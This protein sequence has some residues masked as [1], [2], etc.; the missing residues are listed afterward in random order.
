M[1]RELKH[2]DPA[3]ELIS[4]KIKSTLEY[5]V[6]W[7]WS[8]ILPP[9]K[10]PFPVT[11]T[12]TCLHTLLVWPPV[13]CRP[14]YLPAPTAEILHPLCWEGRDFFSIFASRIT[15][16]ILLISPYLTTLIL[17]LWM[18]VLDFNSCFSAGNLRTCQ[19]KH[20]PLSSASAHTFAA[21]T[22]YSS[23][24]QFLGSEGSTSFLL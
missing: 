17:Q 16:N 10:P 18:S 1:G 20:L 13:P 11:D 6:K 19:P 8:T 3:W 7:H 2:G 9:S 24:I 15:T 5:K 12:S 22:D 21:D 14:P 23:S 4:F